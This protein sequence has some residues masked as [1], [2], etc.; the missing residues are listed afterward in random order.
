MRDGVTL[1]S[2]SADRYLK[3]FASRE[4]FAVHRSPSLAHSTAGHGRAPSR[5]ETRRF[6]EKAGNA[7]AASPRRRSANARPPDSKAHLRSSRVTRGSMRLRARRS[8]ER[9]G[10]RCGLPVGR[11]PAYGG[12]RRPC[13]PCSRSPHPRGTDAL[14]S[15]IVACMITARAARMGVSRNADRNDAIVQDPV[16]RGGRASRH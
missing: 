12:I 1:R 14:P 7:S 9:Y 16:A 4:L 5:P 11:C 15:D 13:V 2:E 10:T 8:R 3:S 6:A